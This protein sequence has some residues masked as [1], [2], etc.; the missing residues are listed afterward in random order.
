L[1]SLSRNY[2]QDAAKCTMNSFDSARR[3]LKRG[4]ERIDDV[5]RGFKAFASDPNQPYSL[6]SIEDPADPAYRLLSMVCAR[7]LPED[8]SIGVSE[9]VEHLRSALD[10]ACFAVAV[11]SG[12]QAAKRAYFPFGNTVDDVE[13]AIRGRSR[14][15]PDE[16]VNVIRSLRPYRAG[17]RPLWTL[18]CLA[19]TS[20]HAL[21]T[22]IGSVGDQVQLNSTREHALEFVPPAWDPEKRQMPLA[23]YKR[24]DGKGV[25]Y[26]FR[27]VLSFG[28]VAPGVS[29]APVHLIIPTIISRVEHAV[30]AIEAQAK[31]M[32]LV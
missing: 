10:Q 32:G 21:L 1:G 12:V 19:N 25:K 18:N 22:P 6:V 30:D 8:L 11:A 3:R 7:P 9:G 13:N 5:R 28:Q 15:L 4:A 23:R 14:D 27:P 17:N 29:G 31:A 16:I 24:V 20:K 2:N 26:R